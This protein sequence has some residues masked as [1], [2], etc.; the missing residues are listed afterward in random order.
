MEKMVL[1]ASQIESL[2]TFAKEEG[3][4]K[5]TICHG[6]IPGQDGIDDYSGLIAYSGSEEH[7]VLLLE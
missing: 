3:Q 7:G 2:A 1:T 6:H 5:Y 4:Q